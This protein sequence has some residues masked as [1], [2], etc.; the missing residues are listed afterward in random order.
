MPQVNIRIRLG[1]F[2]FFFVYLTKCYFKVLN[3]PDGDGVGIEEMD[4]LQ[5]EL[6]SIL[7][8]VMQRT[9]SLKVETMVLDNWT[10]DKNDSILVSGVN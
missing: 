4:T 7:V 6:E 5:M 1:A 10:S 3:R 9:R 8:N 2:K